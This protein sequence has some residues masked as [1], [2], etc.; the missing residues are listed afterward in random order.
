MAAMS[1]AELLCY[2]T[3]TSGR[4]KRRVQR[5][6]RGFETVVCLTS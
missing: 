2:R 3:A 5:A 6:S 4:V 1:G